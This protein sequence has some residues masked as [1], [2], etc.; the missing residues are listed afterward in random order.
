MNKLS[1][2]AVVG[3]PDVGKSRLFNRLTKKRISIVHDQPGVTR[4]VISADVGDLYTLLDTGGMGLAPG[5]TS[6][7]IVKAVDRQVLFAIEMADLIVFVLDGIDGINALDLKVAEAL[8]EAGKPVIAVINKVDNDN[9]DL[10]WEDVYKMGLEDPIIISAEH[11]IGEGHLREVIEEKLKKLVGD[12]K[13]IKEE[14]SGEKRL[15]ISFIGRPNVGKSSL[16]N[17]LLKSDRMI[18]SDVP[19]TTRE[20]IELDFTYRSK[21]GEDWFFRL[22]D[23]AGIKKRTKIGSSVEYFSQVR[24]LGAIH[25]ADVVY[26]VIDA[27]DGV[28]QQDKMIAGEAVKEN[29]PLVLVVNKWDLSSAAF[30][31]SDLPQYDSEHKFQN[32][33]AEAVNGQLF[34]SKGSPVVFV[35]AKTGFSIDK[36]LRT[37]R[38]MDAKMDTMFPTAKLNSVL[39]ALYER[40]RAPRIDGKRFRMFYAVHTGNRPFRIKLFCNREGKLQD[41]YM[42]YLKSGLSEAFDIEGC[43]TVFDLV[44]KERRY[45]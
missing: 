14:G 40:R 9:Q 23:T 5:D 20:S 10:P 29:K 37:A 17:R 12:K 28:G 3:R 7:Q 43:P 35:S 13:P 24:S 2:V 15:K 1:T 22:A 34:F 41:S 19:G 4:D 45:T 27:V 33:F 21:K 11:G 42:R 36:M 18:V 44:G 16:S 25:R 6:E 26:L 30:K 8:R 32:A 38:K 39:N 31:K